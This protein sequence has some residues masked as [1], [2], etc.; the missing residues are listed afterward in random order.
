MNHL[1]QE[2]LIDYYY[3]ESP[4]KSVI[5]EHLQR[6]SACAETLAELQGDLAAI[7]AIEPPARDPAYDDRVWT[8]L[9]GSL[10]AWP[11]CRRSWFRSDLLRG[12]SYAAACALL[13]AGAFYAGRLWEQRGHPHIAAAPIVSFPPHEHVVLVVLGDHLDRSE[14]L[15]VELKH[16]DADNAEMIPPLRDEARNLLPANHICRKNAQQSGDPALEGALGHLDSLLDQ[17]ANQPGG[18]NAAAIERLQSEMNVEGLLLEVRVLRTRIAAG[19]P[20]GK[21]HS[22]RGQYED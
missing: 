3:C 19:K 21:D 13:V 20:F 14:R 1:S 17:L 16:I 4:D 5:E 7:E 2:E 18:L 15:L 12:L 9:T 22:R 8:S 11:Q 6:C 10:P